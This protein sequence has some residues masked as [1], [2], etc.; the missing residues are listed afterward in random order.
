MVGLPVVSGKRLA[1]YTGVLVRDSNGRTSG[2]LMGRIITDELALTRGRSLKPRVERSLRA[3]LASGGTVPQGRQSAARQPN[4][5]DQWR[6]SSAIL[7]GFLIESLLPRKVTDG[8][9]QPSILQEA[10]AS[11]DKSMGLED[12]FASG[13]DH[14]AW[15][16]ED[17]QHHAIRKFRE[18][19]LRCQGWRDGRGTGVAQV[20]VVDK[21]RR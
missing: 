12:V 15:E 4:L 1:E 21:G 19:L 5:C 7:V 18:V 11:A 14:H 10:T 8:L 9:Q 20:H 16:C 17:V 13:G 3:A 6:M 2:L